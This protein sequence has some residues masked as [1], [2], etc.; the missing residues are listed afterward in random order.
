M[1]LNHMQILVAD[2]PLKSELTSSV[3][4]KKLLS[5]MR[6]PRSAYFVLQGTILYN[7]TPFLP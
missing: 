4:G 3:L 2:F 1:M 5:R 7:N 6:R